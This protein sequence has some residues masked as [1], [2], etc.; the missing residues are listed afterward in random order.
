MAK[1]LTGK[2]V[3]AAVNARSKLML[4]ELQNKGITPKLAILR[5]GEK[6]NDLSYEKGIL[7]RCAELG[8]EYQQVVFPLDAEEKELLLA[9]DQLNKDDSVHGILLF[10]PLPK[11]MDEDF[12][13]NSIA[14]QKDVDGCTN[15]SLAG[16][17]AAKPLGFAP[18]TAQAAMEA[19]DYYGYELQGKNVVVIGRSLVVGK[20]LSMLLSNRHATVTIC[21]SRSQNIAEHTQ[22]ADIVVAAMGKPEILGASYFAENQVVLDVGVSWNEAKGKLTGDVN[23]EEAEKIVSA[24]TPVPR[25][26]GS[27]T[28]A[29]LM[30]HVIISAYQT[31]SK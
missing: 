23:Y 17:F 28:T 31:I 2:E 25:G 4:E 8:V 11:R 5:V 20:P 15:L 18:C 6:E 9:I 7:K 3:A 29:V 30:N 21:H 27:I 14:P 24:I 10:R 1:V 12:I 19:L 26:I 13:V 22:H 16:V